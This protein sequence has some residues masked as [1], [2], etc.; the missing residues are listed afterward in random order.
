M[1]KHYE[2]A[3]RSAQK[4]LTLLRERKARLSEIIAEREA[5]SEGR[6]K[7]RSG[8]STAPAATAAEIMRRF[9]ETDERHSQRLDAAAKQPDKKR[10]KAFAQSGLKEILAGS[11][12]FCAGGVDGDLICEWCGIGWDLAALKPEGHIALAKRLVAM[13]PNSPHTEALD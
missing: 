4:P 10:S 9:E 12:I 11:P 5:G 2:G 1:A 7:H 3:Q 6:R 13:H 8:A